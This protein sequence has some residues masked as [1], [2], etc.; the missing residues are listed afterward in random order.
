MQDKRHPFRFVSLISFTRRKSNIPF[1]LEV[2]VFGI[3]KTTL[4]MTNFENT[5]TFGSKMNTIRPRTI[6]AMIKART[7]D[8]HTFLLD[9]KKLVKTVFTN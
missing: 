1:P 8:R 9:I 3:R 7:G 2:P 5:R 6:Q 4:P